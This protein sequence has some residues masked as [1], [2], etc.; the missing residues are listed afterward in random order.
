[1]VLSSAAAKPDSEPIRL[2]GTCRQY[3]KK[4]IPQLTR[5]AA[6][7]ELC[8]YFR[9]PY[10]AKVMNTLEARSSTMVSMLL[11]YAVACALWLVVC[12]TTFAQFDSKLMPV[13]LLAPARSE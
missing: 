12:S 5:I 9:C 6:I 11:R 2:A 7:S 8:L 4:A 3:S 1:M 13:L 10:Q